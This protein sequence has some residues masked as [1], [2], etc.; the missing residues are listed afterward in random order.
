MVWLQKFLS[1]IWVEN[2]ATSVLHFSVLQFYDF[3]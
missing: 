2:K 3:K 1:S